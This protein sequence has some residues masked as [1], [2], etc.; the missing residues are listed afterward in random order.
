MSQ[1]TRHCRRS[2]RTDL[3]ARG[4]GFIPGNR[5]SLLQ[6]GEACFPALEAAVDRVRHEL[7]LETYMP[8]STNISKVK[9]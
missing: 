8:A 3:S 2:C 1:S 9:R 4:Y 5:V 6:N 7:Y